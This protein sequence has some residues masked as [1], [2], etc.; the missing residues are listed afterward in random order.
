MGAL[1]PRV[2]PAA[3]PAVEGS[4]YR[5]Q[6]G[7][8][9]WGIARSF[10]VDVNTLA[11]VNRLPNVNQLKVGQQVFIPLPSPSARFVWPARGPHRLSDAK[12]MW[13]AVPPGSLVRASRSG[14]VAVATRQLAGWGETI[15]LD[16]GG[17]YVTI[18]AGLETILTT[19]GAVVSQG[20]P[21]GRC[22]DGDLHFEIRR[23]TVV[24]HPLALLP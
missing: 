23:G 12:G 11:T 1:T 17:G 10:G 7:D 4:Y 22:G 8:T 19:P 18:Y 9:L 20:Q 6:R 2:P 21:I 13:I 16:H 24:Q 3:I 5:A 15:V 14:R